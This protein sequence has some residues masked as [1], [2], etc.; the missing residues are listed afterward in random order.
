MKPDEI[1]LPPELETTHALGRRYWDD[2]KTRVKIVCAEKKGSPG[3][4]N[5]PVY[6]FREDG[7][8]FWAERVY[9]DD[10]PWEVVRTVDLQGHPLDPGDLKEGEGT[11]RYYHSNDALHYVATYVGG[12]ATGKIDY[13][14]DTGA[15]QGS[16]HFVGGKRRGESRWLARDGQLQRVEDYRD[17]GS[18]HT[19]WYGEKERKVSEGL[20]RY[21]E[22]LKRWVDDGPTKR[23]D[24]KGELDYTDIYEMGAYVRR[25]H[26]PEPVLRALS[27]TKNEDVA[28]QLRA[29]KK[30]AKHGQVQDYLEPLHETGELSAEVALRIGLDAWS[31]TWKQALPVLFSYGE[32]ML[33]MLDAA[34]AEWSREKHPNENHSNVI[35]IVRWH[36]GGRGALPEAFLPVLGRAL[37][38]SK[39]LSDHK[40]EVVARLREVVASQPDDVREALVMGQHDPNTYARGHAVFAYADLAPTEEAIRQAISRVEGEKK[41]GFKYA[42]DRARTWTAFLDACAEMATPQLVA[43][44]EGKGAKAPGRS[45]LVGALAKSGRVEAVPTLLALLADKLPEVQKAA[46]VGLA[47]LGEGGL[48][49]CVEA[50]AGKNRKVATAAAE[51]IASLAPGDAARAAAAR[52]LETVKAKGIRAILEP[53]AAGAAPSAAPA[54]SAPTH[55]ALARIAKIREALAGRDVIAELPTETSHS[56][57]EKAA[58]RLVKTEPDTVVPLMDYL[59]EVARGNA[60]RIHGLV[61]SS[62]GWWA[63]DKE[64]Y[65]FLSA[66]IAMSMDDRQLYYGLRNTA[67]RAGDAGLLAEALSTH[68]AAGAAPKGEKG[69][70]RW[71]I[72]NGAARAVPGFIAMAGG[73]KAVAALAHEG[74]C[75]AGDP[76]REAALRMLAGDKKEQALA[77]LVLRDVPHAGSIPA[78]E[79]AWKKERNKKQK[80]QLASTLLACRLGAGE[81]DTAALDAALSE[82]APDSVYALKEPVTLHYADGTPMSDAAQR[83]LLKELQD[84]AGA[85]ANGELRAIRER[86]ADA[87]CAELSASIRETFRLDP[88]QVWVRY[89]IVLM[90]DESEVNLLGQAIPSGSAALSGHRVRALLRRPT[91][92]AI[93]W[94][95]HWATKGRGKV[96]ELTKEALDLLVSRH[97]LSR[98]DLVDAATPAEPD[99]TA[100]RGLIERLETAMCAARRWSADRWRGLFLEH[101]AFA[102]HGRHLLFGTFDDRGQLVATFRVV[103]GATVDATGAPVALS[104]TVGIAHPVELDDDTID[105][106]A[107]LLVTPPFEQLDRP[108]TR[109][110]DQVL[111]KAFPAA[112]VATGELL[113]ALRREGFVDAPAEDAGMVYQAHRNLGGGYRLTVSHDGFYAGNKRNP[114]GPTT[115][116]QGVYPV[117]PDDASP[118][119][120]LHSEALRVA[121]ALLPT[122][123]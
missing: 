19:T 101:P 57:V 71:M 18:L 38:T 73:S 9:R 105:A 54:S 89:M 1:Q 70:L 110:A 63:S 86:L 8:T 111:A 92:T 59:V 119:P 21:D 61:E 32:A 10:I 64:V 74:L 77:A 109:G 28:S 46:E 97:G 83:Y 93:R 20:R 81:L 40:R 43:S 44:L 22:A 113:D 14:Y 29:L 96:A 117:C 35:A 121:R 75:A 116:V 112:P 47:A 36:V 120:A 52:A 76:G 7:E 11:V 95:D 78:L 37:A 91:P 88:K 16:S 80:A 50:A 4:W 72:D 104:S 45:I 12:Q 34:L 118:P 25:L 41:S 3:T 39:E 51:H 107:E 123:P 87:D 24:E 15:L 67:E 13:F 66:E 108:F 82:R 42:P 60:P 114:N 65:A 84:D 102:A 56:A 85:V 69:M 5:G 2:A 94:L 48:D 49:A 90:G 30:A 68:L 62:I 27:Q 99:A 31:T 6:F 23:Y 55:P 98:E 106:Y 17:D 100:A 115:T 26:N 53:V 122:L 58:E 103:D 33:P 79:A